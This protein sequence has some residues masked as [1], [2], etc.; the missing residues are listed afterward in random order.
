MNAKKLLSLYG[1]KWNPFS[2]EVPV[3]GLL[4]TKRVE[5][6]L[7]R[8]ENLLSGGGFA[9][10]SGDPGTGKSAT[11]RLLAERLGKLR[12]VTVGVLTR[13]QSRIGDFY[14]ELGD[15]FALK[16]NVSNRYGGFRALRERWRAHMESSLLRPIVLVDE[17][18]EMPAEVLSELRILASADFDSTSLLTVVLAGDTRLLEKLKSEELAP[19]GSRIRVRLHLE[20]ASKEELRELLEHAIARAGNPSLMTKELIHTLVEH[21]AGNYRALMAMAAELLTSG[22][23]KEAQRLDEKLYLEVFDSAAGRRSGKDRRV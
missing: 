20:Y 15:L 5:N 22:M 18:Q 3:E 7:W 16:L 2:P 6:F 21:A 12:D 4:V 17:A 9:L 10:L 13:P 19:L 23:A 11:L 14:R 8:V 1:L